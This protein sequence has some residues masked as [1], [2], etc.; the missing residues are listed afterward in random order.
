[1]KGSQ[2]ISRLGNFSQHPHHISKLWVPNILDEPAL[3]FF[4]M[5]ILGVGPPL[6]TDCQMLCNRICFLS[7]PRTEN[8]NFHVV[9]HFMSSD[10][11]GNIIHSQIDFF[12]LQSRGRNK[13]LS[14][15]KRILT[16]EHDSSLEISVGFKQIGFMPLIFLKT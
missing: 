14:R 3:V 1:M 2:K 6:P 12:R 9:R 16:T 8:R 13:I 4:S 11:K 7:V 5:S 15:E 10:F